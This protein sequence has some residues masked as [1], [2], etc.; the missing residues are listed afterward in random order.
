MVQDIV[1]FDD[2]RTGNAEHI[3]GIRVAG[4]LLSITLADPLRTSPRAS[5]CRSSP[6]CRSARRRSPSGVG[7]PL[8]SAGPYYVSAHVGDLAEVVKRNPNYSGPRPQGLDAFVFENGVDA[9]AGASRV[10]N[11]KDDYA[12]AEQPPYPDNL[13]PTS[14]FARRYGPGSAAAGTG[15]QRYFNPAFSGVQAL[16]FSARSKAL[17]DPSV[18]RA[19]GFAL[20]RKRL[21]AITSSDPYQDLLPAGIPGT[22]APAVYPLDGP[23]VKRA[24]ALMHGRHLTLT[25][26]NG[27]PDGCPRC[28]DTANVLRDNLGAIGITLQV[29]EVDDRFG[30]A[31]SSSS[32]DL[33][34]FTWFADYADPSD[35][36]NGLYSPLDPLGYGYAN[37][38]PLGPG[39]EWAKRMRAAYAVRGTARAGA[40]RRLVT[41]LLRS[42]PPGAVYGTQNGPAQV[43]SSRIGCQVF[44]PQDWGYVDLAALCLRGKS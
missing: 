7:Q 8:P 2:Y 42:A 18:R 20:D 40:Y 3:S 27:T 24:L 31:S 39:G 41:D 4:D 36:I 13:L 34:E 28:A 19:I 23:E 32:W 12:F 21:A 26:L 38:L 11:G 6:P 17:V 29:R 33:V 9:G 16:M 10:M 1:G 14:S 43:F 30:E 37:P 44:R 5:R 15:Q 22:G 35:F 25:Y